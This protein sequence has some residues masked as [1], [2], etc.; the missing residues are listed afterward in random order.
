M[1]LLVEIK[2]ATKS[3][4]GLLANNK[5]DFDL[6]KGEIHVLLGENGA[7]KS[8]LMGILYGLIKPDSGKIYIDGRQVSWNSPREAIDAGIGLVH[9][10]FLLIPTLS[11]VENIAI[12]NRYTKRLMLDLDAVRKKICD[13]G[14]ELGLEVDPD[15]RVEDLAVALQQRVEILKCL[16]RDA[17]T[18]IL[19]EPTALLMPQEIDALFAMLR[20]LKQLGKG[21]ILITHKL[22]E[23]MDISDRVTVLRNG[24][25][26][27]TLETNKTSKTELANL[28]IGHEIKGIT[29]RVDSA[30]NEAILKVNS[31]SVVNSQKRLLIDNVSF[32]V[33]KGEILGV[34]GVVGN[35]QNELIDV[36]CGL[37]KKSGGDITFNG[38]SIANIGRAE[39]LRQRIAHIPED[40]QLQALVMDM[41]VKENSILG[42]QRSCR[43][44]KGPLLEEKTIKNNIEGLVA[45]YGIKTP[46]VNALSRS[47]S[48]GHQQRLVLSRELSKNPELIV[49]VQLTRGLDI[50]STAYVHKKLLEQRNNGAA[51]ILVSTDLEEI[52]SLSDRIMVMFRGRAVG[53]QKAGDLTREQ[54]G[55]MMA[56]SA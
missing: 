50:A 37:R 53:L 49:A 7:G 32:E 12:G 40:R 51:V 2:Q 36:I 16:I 21:I 17:R 39:F 35:G 33:Y 56:G 52:L 10:H 1:S 5:V 43:F 11:V 22:D 38:C 30:I 18:V 54:L 47:L 4:N 29:G 24:K 25:R 46:H 42:L 8:T 34:A 9:Q 13:L 27:E 3:Y 48:G 19:D 6:K 15:A 55:L 41:S 28:M 45:E 26:I 14:H 31:L 23:V 44:N 20:K